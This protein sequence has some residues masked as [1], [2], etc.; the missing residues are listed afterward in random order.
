MTSTSD[1]PLI[2]DRT[3]WLEH[4]ASS[5]DR[6]LW[7]AVV[8]A[9]GKGTRLGYELPKILFPVAGRPILAWLLDLLLPV[10]ETVVLVLSPDGCVPVEAEM[11]RIAPGRCRIAIQHSATGMGDAVDIGAA[12][13]S[14]LHT[15]V[16]WGDQ[17]AV[18]PASVDCVLR[19]HQGPRNPD[20]TVPTVF[21]ES[22][23]IHF[24]RHGEGR[25][26][27]LLQAREGDRMPARGESDTGFFCFRTECLRRLIADMRGTP[28]SVG[29]GTGEFNFLPVIPFAAAAGQYVLTPRLMDL[30]ETVGINSKADA[31]QL[32][33]YLRQLI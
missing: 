3:N 16:I 14:T 7:T 22:P 2:I 6:S 15:A 9:A 27:G 17:V 12:G 13:V 10:C 4:A 25:I 24:E 8:P 18:R 32:E 21:R 20:L 1:R 29:A 31:A 5:V 26:T 19:L 23:Y 33:P 11:E 30:A 28:L